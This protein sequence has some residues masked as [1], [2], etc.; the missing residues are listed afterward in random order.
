MDAGGPGRVIVLVRGT[1]ARLGAED[2]VVCAHVVT[3]YEPGSRV[4]ATLRSRF[5]PL[6]IVM[7]AWLI[8]PQIP[9]LLRALTLK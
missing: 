6:F 1:R 7:A 8:G 4:T 5:K 9:I 2:Q 3:R